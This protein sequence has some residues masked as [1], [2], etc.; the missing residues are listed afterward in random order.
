MAAQIL[1]VED[2]KDLVEYLRDFLTKQNYIVWVVNDGLKALEVVEKTKPDLII[3][4]LNLPVMKGE[5][6]CKEVKESYP[7][8]QIIMLTAKDRTS[9]L[10]DGFSRGADDYVKKP[11][12]IDELL[13]RIKA[14]LKEDQIKSH[15]LIVGD[16][17]YNPKTLIVK[18]AGREIFLTPQELKILEYLMLNKEQVLSRDMILSRLWKTDPD[19][20]TRVVDVYIGYLRKKID[21]PFDSKLIHSVRGFGYKLSVPS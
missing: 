4:D 11:F 6:V 3:L 16:L 7:E 20:E 19:I 14:R 10:V 5:V 12:D 17:E 21:A 9:D 2:D 8:I 13:M 18:R 15:T 1:L